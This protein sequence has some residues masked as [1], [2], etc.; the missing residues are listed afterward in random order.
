MWAPPHE[1][2][3]RQG[4]DGPR[5]HSL[6]VVPRNSPS[7]GPAQE[8][9]SHERVNHRLAQRPLEAPEPRRLL[10]CEAESGH[11]E[12]FRFDSPD[13]VFD[14]HATVERKMH[15][16]STPCSATPSISGFVACFAPN[17]WF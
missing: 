16:G 7:L 5:E 12:E 13:D 3:V 8:G 9:R 1:A 11:L 4:L 14:V 17:S 2:E 15:A 10:H 6:R